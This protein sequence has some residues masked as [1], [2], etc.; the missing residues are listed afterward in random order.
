MDSISKNDAYTVPGIFTVKKIK[1]KLMKK[2][3]IFSINDAPRGSKIPIDFGQGSSLKWYRSGDPSTATLI[4]NRVV[5]D[6]L[7]W[8]VT[9]TIWTS[10]S[11]VGL[12]E[13]GF[14]SRVKWN[15]R[16][17]AKILRIKRVSGKIPSTS[18]R[19]SL[20]IIYETGLRRT[21]SIYW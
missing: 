19:Y 11:E 3:W 21:K 13:V 12:S 8:Y 16:T 5:G 17:W 4:I 7:S 1:T 6:H 9:K 18:N 2:V 14:W 10:N 15:I 20:Y